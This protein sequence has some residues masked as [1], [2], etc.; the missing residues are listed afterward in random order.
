[1]ERYVLAY[2]IGTSSLK[3]VAL[4]EEG[5]VAAR[6]ASSYHVQHPRIRWAEQNPL[7]WWDAFIACTKE[8]LLRIPPSR[9]KAVS[10][11]SQE[12]CTLPVDENGIGLY[13]AVIWADSRAEA[14]SAEIESAV[15]EDAYYRLVGMRASPNYPL[16]KIL[17]MKKHLPDVYAS[18]YCFLN[19]KDYINHRLTGIFA[20]DP[21][22]AAY[23][24]CADVS[25]GKWSEQLLSSAGID[26][27]KFPQILETGTVLGTVTAKA[28][29]LT[30]LCKDTLVVMGMGDGGAATLGT[31]ILNRNEGYTS[32][33]TS[34]WVCIVSGSQLLDPQRR[35]SKIRYLD[36][37]RDT[38]TM[39]T[40]GHSYKWFKEQFCAEERQHASLTGES[41]YEVIDRLA[42]ASPPGSNG[43]F[44]MPYLMGERSP[45]WNP[46][47][48]GG[49][50]GLR[51]DTLK[52][53]ICRS[54]LEGVALHLN[55]ILEAIRETNQ[56]GDIRFM[57]LVGGGAKSTLW[58]QIFADVYG[59]PVQTVANPEDAGAL[60]MGVVA[61]KAAG[62]Y[63]D[64]SVLESMQ[65]VVSVIEPN[66]KRT[67]K[68]RQ[69]FD[70]FKKLYP[71][72]S[73]LSEIIG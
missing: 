61:G 30:G 34:S 2:D 28:S 51:A 23:M 3:A 53:D 67:A 37:L 36:T 35:I 33:G 64:Y 47:L 69:V 56:I 11:C 25:T 52:T 40:G 45:Y 22:A 29:E 17:W 12:M 43:V 15:G 16:S 20:T 65:P 62:I 59:L 24:H 13:P 26:A 55:I 44:F 58:Q 9:I 6:S 50:L 72:Y 39:Q 32:L 42:E 31:G 71:A 21:E 70:T 41:S 10:V 7:S 57:R 63:P 14:E 4:D 48:S 38:G 27:D 54:V 66:E 49:F 8:L 46:H 68:Y 18:T 1:M 19:P 60:G 73:V 5:S